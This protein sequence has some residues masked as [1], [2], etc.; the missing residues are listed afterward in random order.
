MK[1]ELVEEIKVSTGTMYAVKK[2]GYGV[3]WFSRKEEA[4]KFYDA[5]IADP[6]ILNNVENILKSQEIEVSLPLSNQ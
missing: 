2:D 4:E 1:I 5:V 3:K 6:N